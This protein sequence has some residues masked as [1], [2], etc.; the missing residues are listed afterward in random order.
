[1][2]VAFDTIVAAGVVAELSLKNA[3]DDAKLLRMNK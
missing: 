2:R 3:L 1:M